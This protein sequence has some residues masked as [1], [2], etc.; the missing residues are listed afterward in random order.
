M[1]TRLISAHDV[2]TTRL[3]SVGGCPFEAA[4]GR[5]DCVYHVQHP[6]QQITADMLDSDE[7]RCQAYIKIKGI[8]RNRVRCSYTAKDNGYCAIHQPGKY[9]NPCPSPRMEKV[10]AIV[11]ELE[12]TGRCTVV[13]D[14]IPAARALIYQAADKMNETARTRKVG[15]GVIEGWLCGG[16][17]EG[18]NGRVQEVAA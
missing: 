2:L 6:P 13:A 15:P 12:E 14:D 16:T 5:V 4:R 18:S 17:W 9:E 11:R 7:D 3:C 10:R 8:D 1:G